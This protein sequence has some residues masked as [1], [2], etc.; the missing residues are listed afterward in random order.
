MVFQSFIFIGGKG[1]MYKLAIFD[2]DGTILD[3]I[4]DLAD[5]TNHILA[6][7]NYP[8]HSKEDIRSFVGNGIYMLIKRALPKD[9]AE[10]EVLNVQ[11]QF[12]VYYKE[13]CCDKTKPYQGIIELLEQLKKHSVKLAVV[14]NKG[15]FAV[16][17]LMD[18]YFPNLFD[19]SVGE[20]EN[21]RKKP[22]PDSVNEVLRVLNVALQDSVY[23]GDSEVDIQTAKNAKMDCISVSYGFREKQYLIDNGATVICDNIDQLKDLLLKGK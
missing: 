16:K 8:T 22:A 19:Y 10:E 7:N 5:S 20:K 12:S 15:D 14:S 18:D 3:T 13:H 4:D 9:T 23:I 6:I 21:V 17:I 2:L 1:K 11:K